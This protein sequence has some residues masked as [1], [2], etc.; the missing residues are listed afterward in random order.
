MNENAREHF[1]ETKNTLRIAFSVAKDLLTP[2]PLAAIFGDPDTITKDFAIRVATLDKA[3]KLIVPY[4]ETGIVRGNEICELVLTEFERKITGT[5]AMK[6]YNRDKS[7]EI[8][9][10]IRKLIVSR[11]T[12]M[13]PTTLATHTTLKRQTAP[14]IVKNNA[15]R[16]RNEETVAFLVEHA[17]IF[18]DATAVTT[19]R[20]SEELRKVAPDAVEAARIPRCDPSRKISGITKR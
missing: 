8:S 18:F 16:A 12:A 5:N 20:L 19:S 15:R 1:E 2:M 13:T 3:I 14:Y 17:R 11:L 6:G 4:I 10:M 9:E 7:S